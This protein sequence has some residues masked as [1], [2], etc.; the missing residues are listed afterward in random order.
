M[1]TVANICCYV[2]QFEDTALFRAAD[3]GCEREQI[4]MVTH[5][6]SGLPGVGRTGY[7][8]D[9]NW[10]ARHRRLTTLMVAVADNDASLCQSLLEA[11]GDPNARIDGRSAVFVAASKGH[12]EVLKLLL[13]AGGDPWRK[14]NQGM[15]AL[16][17]A[18]EPS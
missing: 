17:H 5:Q 7:N 1:C 18:V 10:A 3:A 6:G 8:P 15:T 11:A 4:E 13:K 9:P 16:H 2:Q 14:D 12:A